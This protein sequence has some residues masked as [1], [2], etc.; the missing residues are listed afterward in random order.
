[1]R[2]NSPA[3]SNSGSFLFTFN[4]RDRLAKWKKGVNRCGWFLQGK[5]FKTLEWEA[6]FFLRRTR[7]FLQRPRL[8]GSFC[9]H[10]R[11]GID[12]KKRE[13]ISSSIGY[14]YDCLLRWDIFSYI[15]KTYSLHSNWDSDALFKW[16][17]MIENSSFH[18]ES[19]KLHTRRMMNTRLHFSQL[20][21]QQPFVLQDYNP[22]LLERRL[23]MQFVNLK[24][25]SS[26]A[27]C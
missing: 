19:R 14:M 21:L 25:V 17:Y 6:V 10:K 15:F 24:M 4:G 23:K 13:G 26:A 12:E 20:I 11:D 2:G 3:W 22:K 5:R 7:Y 16:I 9:A 18:S 1:M 27:L 8:L